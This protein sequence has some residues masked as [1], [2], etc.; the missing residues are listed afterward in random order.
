[1]MT[2]A[3]MTLCILTALLVAKSYAAAEDV[4]PISCVWLTHRTHDPSRIVVSWLSELPGDSTVRFG[5]S[6]QCEETIRVDG[7]ATLHHVE[8]PLAMRDTVYHYRVSTGKQTS[9][10]AKFKAYPTDVLRAAVVAN[11]QGKPD[12]GALAADDPHLLLTAGDNIPDI[13]PECGINRPDCI[14]PY[15]KLVE[16]YPEMFRSTPFMPVLGNHDKQIRP[17]GPAPPEEPVYDVSATAFCRFFALPDS[18]WKWRF[19]VPP[20]N[21]RFIALDFHHISDQDTTWQ[22]SHDFHDQSDQFLWYKD[23]MADRGDRFIVTLYNERNAS[24]RNQARGAWHE[25][26]RKGTICVTGFG[27]YGERAELDGLTYYDISLHGKGIPYP[28]P[29]SKFLAREHNYLLMTF[30]RAARTMTAEIK[31]LAGEVLDRKVFEQPR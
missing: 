31:S 15:A 22:S 7:Y 17:R 2:T 8:I 28:D 27:H 3:R 23:L 10:P 20:F 21:V 12:L 13:Y 1:M 6:E 30:D 26:F 29:H 11:W 19:D 16:A 18:G 14:I 25:M 24:I 5:R 4:R 9:A